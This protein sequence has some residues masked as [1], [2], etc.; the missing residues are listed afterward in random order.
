MNT[1]AYT[2]HIDYGCP[3]LN[4][5]AGKAGVDGSNLSD[6]GT[7][8][9]SFPPLMAKVFGA[10]TNRWR[11]LSEVQ[12]M[13]P[14][15]DAELPQAPVRMNSNRRE[16]GD[17]PIQPSAA[18]VSYRT[19][20]H[21]LYVS[22]TPWRIWIKN[23]VVAGWITVR[24]AIVPVLLHGLTPKNSQDAYRARVGAVI[25]GAFVLISPSGLSVL[26][27]SLAGWV[28][29]ILRLSELNVREHMK[30]YAQIISPVTNSGSAA[31]VPDD[32]LAEEVFP[33][34]YQTA[35]ATV[36]I[37]QGSPAISDSSGVI[38]SV[39]YKGLGDYTINW[40][41]SFKDEHYGFW[42]SGAAGHIKY[43]L[44]RTGVRLL[45]GPVAG[46]SLDDISITIFAIEEL[47]V[48]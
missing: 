31:D 48:G 45:M 30:E 3:S 37:R 8:T 7:N 24:E 2:L 28:L 27:A 23:K 6:G 19:T 35:W 22:S 20:L 32:V 34:R 41:K 36:T 33:R 1:N 47:D 13:P 39:Q 42:V 44:T 46:L 21:A 38:S 29:V 9:L 17:M 11:L 40:V 12:L 15:L 26:I 43:E 18:P 10:V 25:V 4:S 16:R 14:A 5:G